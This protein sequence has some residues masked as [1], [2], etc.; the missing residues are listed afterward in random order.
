MQAFLR[1]VPS[2]GKGIVNIL[3]HMYLLPAPPI[4]P[5]HT[6]SLH[7]G[8]LLPHDMCCQPV[9]HNSF[10]QLRK[11]GDVVVT[12]MFDISLAGNVPEGKACHV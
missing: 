10:Q 7:D 3:E 1:A 2:D 6:S 9:H 8:L 5:T 4:G 11:H 12:A